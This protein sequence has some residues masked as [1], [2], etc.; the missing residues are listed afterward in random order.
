MIE[1]STD[2]LSHQRRWATSA[3]FRLIA[4]IR[5]DLLTRWAVIRRGRAPGR[6]EHV[7]LGPGLCVHD[8]QRI[9]DAARCLGGSYGSIDSALIEA[10]ATSR[11]LRLGELLALRWEDIDWTAGTVN[12]ERILREMKLEP[13][14]CGGPRKVRLAPHTRRSLNRYR[15]SLDRAEAGDLVFSEPRGGGFLETRRLRHRMR[16]ALKRAGSSHIAIAH[17]PWAF[18]APWW[19]RYL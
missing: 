18:K 2:S 7:M 19:S 16:A 5:Q 9:L 13:P 17:L 15:A 14:K 6:C 4:R 3:L 8:L 11:R 1:L 10:A 12:V